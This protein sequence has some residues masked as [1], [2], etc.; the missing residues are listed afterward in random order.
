MYLAKT[1]AIVASLAVFGVAA[2][3]GRVSC[4]KRQWEAACGNQNDAPGPDGS[5]WDCLEKEDGKFF[6]ELREDCGGPKC[7]TVAAPYGPECDC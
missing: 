5:I 4:E 2:K 7:C 6:W 1:L 3:D